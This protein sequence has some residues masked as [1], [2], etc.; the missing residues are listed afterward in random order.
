[1]VLQEGLVVVNQEF[2]QLYS[3]SYL[4]IQ[5]QYKKEAQ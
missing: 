4:I 3:E 1:M 5:G 2:S